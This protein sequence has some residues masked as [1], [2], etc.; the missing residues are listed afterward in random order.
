ML[1]Y[2]FFFHD[3]FPTHPSLSLSLR[4]SPTFETK[5]SLG[6]TREWQT[7]TSFHIFISSSF[8]SSLEFLLGFRYFS[9]KF[10]R[11]RNE[12]KK[13]DFFNTGEWLEMRLYHL[14]STSSNLLRHL[15][16]TFRFPFRFTRSLF[17]PF[18]SR[19]PLNRYKSGAF[20]GQVIE[21]G[22]NGKV[23]QTNLTRTLRDKY[24]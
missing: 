22:S 17:A 1:R 24:T 14:F 16:A 15:A 11:Y 10:N 9:R 18:F 21:A 2:R 8:A 3:F 4:G 6:D 20:P 5:F 23:G 13:I 19:S 12:K 7:F